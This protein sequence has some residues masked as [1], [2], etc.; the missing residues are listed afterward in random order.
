[1]NILNPFSTDFPT[2]LNPALLSHSLFSRTANGDTHNSYHT[3]FWYVH[4]T[5][6]SRVK[7]KVTL[8][9]ISCMKGATQIIV[10]IFI[11]RVGVL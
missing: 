9:C 5:R 10:I 1:M 2:V 11:S 8:N 3:E 6:Y 4:I 7:A